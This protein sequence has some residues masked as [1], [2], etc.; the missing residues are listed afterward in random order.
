MLQKVSGKYR[1]TSGTK[2]GT[3]KDGLI[4]KKPADRSAKQLMY[5]QGF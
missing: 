2:A 1:K 3:Q 5:A 4:K